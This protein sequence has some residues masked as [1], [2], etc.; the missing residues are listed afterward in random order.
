MYIKHMIFLRGECSCKLES[1]NKEQYIMGGV[2][3]KYEFEK[4]FFFFLQ[5]RYYLLYVSHI[6]YIKR[7]ED[8]TPSNKY[9]YNHIQ[10]VQQI[11]HYF[12][13]SLSHLILFE[14][15]C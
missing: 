3:M 9:N 8:K 6:T 10:N 14:P 1:M 13:F 2:G 15:S 4:V 12:R 7:F 5:L 11:N